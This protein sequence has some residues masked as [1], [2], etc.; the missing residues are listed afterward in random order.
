MPEI[1][2]PSRLDLARTPTPLE[3]L[4]RWSDRIGH[5]LWIKR[6]DETGVALSGNKIRKL[7][8]LLPEAAEQRADTVITCGGVNS[9]HARATAVACARLGLRLSKLVLRGADRHPATGNLLLDR[10]VGA[11][12]EF[13][14]PEQWPDVNAIMSARADAHAATGGRAYVVPEGGSNGLGAMGYVR[15]AFELLEDAAA[16]EIRIGRVVHA[17]GQWRDDGGPGARLRARR[18]GLRGVRGRLRV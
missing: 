16:A 1:A 6:D 14:T 12:V 4:D 17:L 8:F 2:W 7:E 13:I 9:N 3:R 11:E 18:R 5:E 15:T 10:W